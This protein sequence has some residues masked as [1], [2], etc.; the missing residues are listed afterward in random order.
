MNKN[1]ARPLQVQVFVEN[2]NE[3]LP[4]DSEGPIP[5]R[6]V[7]LNLFLGM[8]RSYFMLHVVIGLYTP[9]LP[10]SGCCGPGCTL[11]HAHRHRHYP[12]HRRSH[13][14]TTPVGI[15][16]HWVHRRQKHRPPQRTRSK[17][18]N[19]QTGQTSSTWYQNHFFENCSRDRLQLQTTFDHTKFVQKL[20]SVYQIIYQLF[21]SIPQ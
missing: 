10:R 6:P 8:Y 20:P 12:R 9:L 7:R 18:I 14:T 21:K 2:S 5:D 4:N 3:N 11:H 16:R 19:K 13:Q 17:A 15:L 1:V